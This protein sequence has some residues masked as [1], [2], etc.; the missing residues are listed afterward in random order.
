M[1]I[2]ILLRHGQST[3]NADGILAGWAPQVALTDRG[4]SEAVAAG[5]RLAGVPVAALYCSPVQR[6]QETAAALGDGVPAPVLDDRLGET[7]YGAWTGRVLGELAQEPLWRTIQDDPARASFPEGGEHVA[8]SMT[9][10]AERIWEALVEFDAAVTQLHGPHA[11]WVAVSHGDPIKAA[12]AQ[13]AGVGI[14]G[15]QRFRVDPASMSV[16]ARHEG[17]STIW[18]VNTTAGALTAYLRASD[19]EEVG[20]GD[21]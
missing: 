7:H 19:R 16:I 6:C 3:A 14:G 13:A 20:G 15:I 9:Q 12:L 8:E 18:A 10:M 1:A 2:C 17:R 4:R 5:E 21:G 11:L